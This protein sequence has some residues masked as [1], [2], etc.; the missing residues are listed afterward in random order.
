MIAI[1]ALWRYGFRRLPLNDD[2]LY[3][4]AVVPL[5]M[6]AVG[7]SKM[8]HAISLRFLDFIPH[9]FFWIALTAWL[10]AFAGTA[11]GVVQRLAQ[12]PGIQVGS[13]GSV[14]HGAKPPAL[15]ARIAVT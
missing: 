15:A 6:Y 4:G 10:L 7:T 12:A 3:W 2:P 11:R 1:L 9:A 14:H 8:A 13:E 5:G